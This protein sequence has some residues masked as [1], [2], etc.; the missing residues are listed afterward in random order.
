MLE[1]LGAVTGVGNIHIYAAMK[2]MSVEDF[3]K[4]RNAAITYAVGGKEKEASLAERT[5]DPR[6]GPVNVLAGFAARCRFLGRSDDDREGAVGGQFYAVGPQARVL[7]GSDHALDVGLPPVP[8]A[9]CL[10]LTRRRSALVGPWLE[11]RQGARRLEVRLAQYLR[12]D[13]EWSHAP[14]QQRGAHGC[15][16]NEPQ[17]TRCRF[18]RILAVS[19]LQAAS[20]AKRGGQASAS[21]ET[22]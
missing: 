14:P 1:K 9:A 18:S 22:I 2:G 20:C 19:P 17:K 3:Q 6:S 10:R 7:G 16:P 11:N 5:P 15:Q 4:T 8:S 21:G 12:L 13:M